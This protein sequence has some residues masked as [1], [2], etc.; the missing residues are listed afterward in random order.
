MNYKHF[1][2]F[3]FTLICTLTL[4]QPAFAHAMPVREVPRVGIT[5]IPSPAV[6]KI[7]FDEALARTGS[8]LQVKNAAGDIVS[9]GPSIVA[10][11]NPKLLEVKLKPL[12]PG[13]YHVYWKALSADRHYTQGDYQF[14]VGETP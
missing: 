1:A 11:D 8:A 12:L 2:I 13:T 14:T 9:I 5:V 6:V 10:R 3:C 7:W 4:E